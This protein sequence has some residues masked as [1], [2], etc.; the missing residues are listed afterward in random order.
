VGMFA[1]DTTG[2]RLAADFDSFDYQKIE[3]EER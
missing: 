2:N 3:E 1:I